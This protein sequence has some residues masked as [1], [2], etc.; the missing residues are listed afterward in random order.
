MLPRDCAEL[1][2]SER[3]AQVRVMGVGLA[4]KRRIETEVG[5]CAKDPKFFGFDGNNEGEYMSIA[6]FLVEKLR[7]FESFKGRSF[8]SYV[9]VVERHWRMT[10]LFEPIRAALVGRELSVDE[11]IQLS[12][13]PKPHY[14]N[15]PLAS[16]SGSFAT[17]GHASLVRLP[18]AGRSPAALNRRG[19]S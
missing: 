19:A 2:A 12:S 8:N 18:R 4:A 16:N 1:F 10:T 14:V 5:P 15:H 7:H 11:V 9:P 17:D 13:A 6:S 3:G